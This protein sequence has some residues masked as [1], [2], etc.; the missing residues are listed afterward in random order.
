LNHRPSPLVPT[1]AGFALILLI[2]LGLIAAGIGLVRDLG[3]RIAA[4][5]DLQNRKMTL[6]VD[7]HR[8]QRERSRILTSLAHLDDAFERDAA[9]MHF[10]GLAIP[11]VQARAQFA[12]MPLDADELAVWQAIRRDIRQVEVEAEAVFERLPALRSAAAVTAATEP[13]RRL[14]ERMLA[15]WERMIRLQQDKNAAA[16]G[17]AVAAEGKARR[18]AYGMGGTA[19][20]V[21]LFMA[22]LAIRLARRQEDSLRQERDKAEFTLEAIA[23]AVLRYDPAGRI[24]YLNPAARQ[25]TGIGPDEVEG[26]EIGEWVRLYDHRSREPLFA[27]LLEQARDGSRVALPA[28]ARLLGGQGIELEVEGS[29]RAI[30][31]ATGE[32]RALVLVLRDVTETREWLRQ[33][34]D[35]W[36]R[37]PLTALPGRRYLENR[38]AKILINKRA[39]DL[40]LTCLLVRLT[41]AGSLAAEAGREAGDA[42]LRQAVALMRSRLR[43]TDLICR[44]DEHDFGILL[45]A[46]PAEVSA[47]I[48][49]DLR[50]ALERFQFTWQGR[51]HLMTAALGTVRSPPFEG[52]VDELLTRAAVPT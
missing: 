16:R 38:L 43:D 14:Q 50:A 44:I 40:P 1:V 37:D 24:C 42:L 6:A 28:D 12:A 19:L 3:G 34:P 21:S 17:A 47:R 10:H 49:A 11:F 32:M 18:L 30:R 13:A 7:M 5:V 48:E 45:T 15:G 39:A 52:G 36:D 8:L 51:D 31:D 41:G 26:K 2:M 25:M 20:A 33:Q 4:I 35:L 23:E 22:V 46:C 27:R 29:C 9:V